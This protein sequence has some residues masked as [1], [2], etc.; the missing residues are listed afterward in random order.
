MREFKLIQTVIWIAVAG[1][2]SASIMILV[3]KIVGTE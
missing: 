3:L 2:I 1:L